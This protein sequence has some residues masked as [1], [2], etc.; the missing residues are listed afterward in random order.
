MTKEFLTKLGVAD[1]LIPQIVAESLKETNAMQEKLN[2]ATQDLKDANEK[3]RTAESDKA[4]AVKEVQD[5]LDAA[6]ADKQS[7]LDG[8]KLDFSLNSGLEKANVQSIKAILPYIDK[9]KLKIEDDKLTGLDEQIE[10]IKKS[11]PYLFKPD[12][13]T[14]PKPHFSTIL[15]GGSG[16]NSDDAAVRAIMGLPPTA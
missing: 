4:T 7:A 9:S 14:E 3:L 15:N 1:E 5:K 16:G 10:A 2:T 13:P 6:E 8:L 12:E 11:D